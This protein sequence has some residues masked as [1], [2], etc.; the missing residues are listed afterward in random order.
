MDYI[1]E[2]FCTFDDFCKIFEANLQKSLLTQGKNTTNRSTSL[3]LSEIMTIV[4]MFHQSGYRFFKYYYCNMLQMFWKSA[5]PKLPSYQRMIELMPRCLQALSSFFH[6][7]K[8]QC[9][10]ISIIDST[11]IVVCHNKRIHQHQVFKGLAQRG[12]S[13]TGWFYGFKLHLVINHLGDI[14]EAKLTAG[15]VHDVKLL[16]TLSQHLEGIL[17]ADKGY[18]SKALAAA[19]AAQGLKIL[20]T[21]RHNM[22]NPPQYSETEKSLLRKRGLIETVNDQLKNLHQIEHS[23]HRSVNNFLVNLMAGI[24]AY[25]LSPNK[26]HF[27]NKIN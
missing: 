12:K 10:G 24:V 25:C 5:F 17:L 13:T 18:V 4:V 14:I 15:N 16:E 7:V 2:M 8:G 20:T 19:L 21:P 11:K 3:S 27:K 1:T 9:T 6:H 23:R 22:K 26:P